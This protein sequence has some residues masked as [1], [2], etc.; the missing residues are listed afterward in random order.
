M[1]ALRVSKTMTRYATHDWNC[2]HTWD[3]QFT[4]SS[5]FRNVVNCCVPADPNKHE[6]KKVV[7]R[8]GRCHKRKLMFYN[9]PLVPVVFV[10]KHKFWPQ[11]TSGRKTQV[12]VKHRFH[13][14]VWTDLLYQTDFSNCS[15][16]WCE[17]LRFW[18]EVAFFTTT[19]T[20]VSFIS[21]SQKNQ[22]DQV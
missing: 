12:F 6:W 17:K 14:T 13:S 1:P 15:K 9:H 11:M 21:S 2:I 10:L 18:V 22:N 7:S 3:K 20:D 19:S 8:Y 16:R 4:A 5:C